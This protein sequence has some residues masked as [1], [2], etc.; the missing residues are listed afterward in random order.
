MTDSTLSFPG[1][2]R[3]AWLIASILV[4][5]VLLQ[6]PAPTAAQGD[7]NDMQARDRKASALNLTQIGIALHS[8]HDKERHLPPPAICDARGKPLLSWRV[9]ILPYLD[10]ADLYKEF[11]LTEPWDSRHNKALLKKMPKAYAPVG[12]KTREPYTTFY[13]A[14]VGPGAAW[15]LKPDKSAPLGAASLRLT[16]F[17][18]GLSHTILVVEAWDPVPWTKPT[19]VTYDPKKK[20][21]KLGG[22]LRNGFNVL[23]GDGTVRFLSNRLNEKT[24]RALITR[25]GGEVLDPAPR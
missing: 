5:F 19:D 22:L 4:A 17:T 13:Q 9:A 3:A 18:D 2:V 25:A 6:G 14:V 24:L 11:K 8:F 15:E 23:V 16:D 12:V 7:P 10:Q 1:R 21:P 20:L